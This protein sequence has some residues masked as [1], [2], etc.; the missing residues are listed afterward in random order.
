M[1]SVSDILDEFQAQVQ[2]G[3]AGPVNGWTTLKEEA[4]AELKALMKSCVPKEIP[5]DDKHE[6][7]I[8][9]GEKGLTIDP[10]KGEL[11][12][13]AKYAEDMGWN[14]AREETL[15]NIRKAFE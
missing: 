14:A 3:Y 9:E 2:D 6:T 12:L 8:V 4:A 1:K 13:L 15:A 5:I 11:P 7:S 10:D